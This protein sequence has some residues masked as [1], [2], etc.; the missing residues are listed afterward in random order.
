MSSGGTLGYVADK[1]FKM[2]FITCPIQVQHNKMLEFCLLDLAANYI[3]CI[4]I[5]Y[6]ITMYPQ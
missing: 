5:I 1:R 6:I 4:Y 3:Y 2:F